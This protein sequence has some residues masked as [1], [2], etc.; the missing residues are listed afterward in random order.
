V[1]WHSEVEGASKQGVRNRGRG[2]REGGHGHG[3]VVVRCI[4]M[5]WQKWWAVGAF[6]ALL[7]AVKWQKWGSVI[8][9]GV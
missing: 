4:V 3:E 9:D 6:K 7:I 5:M 2:Q 8:V 1:T